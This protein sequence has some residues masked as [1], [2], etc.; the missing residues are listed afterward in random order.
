MAT[1]TIVRLADQ[2]SGFLTNQ[3]AS[4]TFLTNATAST[5]YLTQTSASTVYASKTSPDFINDISIKGTTP[6]LNFL[7]PS[8]SV[9]STV[10]HFIKS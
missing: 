3:S 5:Q 9:V 8:G 4:L 1:K 6:E 10:I 2:A 7:N